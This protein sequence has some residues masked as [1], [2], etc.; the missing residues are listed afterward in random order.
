M[1]RTDGQQ[2]PP[3]AWLIRAGGGGEVSDYNIEHGLARIGYTNYGRLPDLRSLSSYEDLVEVMRSASSDAPDSALAKPKTIEERAR[4]LWMF[5]TEV[6]V[7][8]LVVMPRMT[9]HIAVGE[10]ETEYWYD[11]SDPDWP[12]RVSVRWRRRK[13]PYTDLKE[14]LLRSIKAPGTIHPIRSPDAPW[15]LQQ[16]MET[17]RD[18]GAQVGGATGFENADTDLSALIEQFRSETGYPTDAHREQERLRAEWAKKLSRENVARLSPGDLLAYTS[19]AV[20][21]GQYVTLKEDLQQQW[22]D[23]LDDAGYNRLLVSIHDLCWGEDELS[24]RIDRLV[25]ADGSSR[26]DTGTTGFAQGNLNATL[27]I[28]HPGRFLPVGSHGGPRGVGKC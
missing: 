1:R 8:H 17:G 4:Q 26:Q 24:T 10:V 13:V 5:G 23:D 18:P 11:E 25:E 27:A 22:I 14:D 16:V 6:R 7:G 3:V 21:Y 12:H 19:N 28:C 20:D 2:E 15:R 9:D